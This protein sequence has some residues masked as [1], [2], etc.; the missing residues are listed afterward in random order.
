MKTPA[1][2]WTFQKILVSSGAEIISGKCHRWGQENRLDEC[3]VSMV[4]TR[5]SAMIMRLDH[6]RFATTAHCSAGTLDGGPAA[7]TCM[8]QGGGVATAQWLLPVAAES[9]TITTVTRGSVAMIDNPISTR[10]FDLIGRY[11]IQVSAAMIDSPISTRI[12]DLVPIG[13]QGA[14]VLQGWC[15]H[16][17]HFYSLLYRPPITARM[18][19]GS[20]STFFIN[21]DDK[22]AKC[23]FD[24]FYL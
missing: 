12:F 23:T 13:L 22:E 19:T 3:E 24:V 1:N 18:H 16:V 15:I 17:S 14:R 2:G 9:G 4:S 7:T 20:D 8:L 11:F 10:I 6:Y 21:R 5:G